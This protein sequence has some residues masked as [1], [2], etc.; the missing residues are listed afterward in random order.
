MLARAHQRHLM[1]HSCPQSRSLP[2]LQALQL[3]AWDAQ[4]LARVCQQ[5][6]QAQLRCALVTCLVL[7]WAAVLA[8]ACV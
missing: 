4:A 6:Q 2:A 1:R 3:V 8:A 7:D 5:L